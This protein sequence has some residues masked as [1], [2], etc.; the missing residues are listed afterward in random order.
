MARIQDHDLRYALA[1]DLHARPFPP[2]RAPCFAAF[3]AAR[4]PGDSGGADRAR[5][6]ALFLAVWLTGKAVKRRLVPKH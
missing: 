3:P 4:K 2:L 1:N 6:H 5:L